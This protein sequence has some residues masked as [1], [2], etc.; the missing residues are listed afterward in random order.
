MNISTLAK[1]SSK[2]KLGRNVTIG[3]FT[4]VHDNVILGDDVVVDSHCVLGY[5]T[6]NSEGSPLVI[7]DRAKIRTHSVFYEGSTFGDDLATG[8]HVMVREKVKAGKN[9]QIGTM[10]DFEGYVEIGDYVR[11]HSNV[12]I[13]QKM[14]IGNFVWIFPSTAFSNDIHPPSNEWSGAVVED[15]VLI[16]MLSCVLPSVRIG[17]R[18]LVGAHSL[19]TKDVEPDTVVGGVPAKKL[20]MTSDIKL[21]DGSGRPAY[22][23][24]AHFHRGYPD[25]IVRS[26]KEEY[27]NG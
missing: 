22:P 8:H 25:E 4:I 1:V 20:C 3:D 17:T 27:G 9:L 26:W 19:V 21:R 2:A 18:S 10:C 12:H 11:T 6:S 13:T 7:G 16:G 5:P 14:K 24:M 15:Y 23:W